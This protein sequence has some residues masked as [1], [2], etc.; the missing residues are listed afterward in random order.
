MGYRIHKRS[1]PQFPFGTELFQFDLLGVPVVPLVLGKL[2]RCGPGIRA[3]G[4]HAIPLL[5]RLVNQEVLRADA[6]LIPALAEGAWMQMPSEYFHGV[7]VYGFHGFPSWEND[8][9]IIAFL[10]QEGSEQLN[11]PHKHWR[12]TCS[13]LIH[14]EHIDCTS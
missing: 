11:Y 8:C 13:I 4:Y 2:L 7:L 3:C 12:L 5:V 9:T 10:L 1:L 6:I 14:H